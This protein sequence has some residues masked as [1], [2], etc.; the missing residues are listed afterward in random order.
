[1]DF[2]LN[3]VT[4]AIVLNAVRTKVKR[5]NNAGAGAN[6]K[7]AGIYFGQ[8]HSEQ[9]DR[10]KHWWSH[11]HVLFALNY[12]FAQRLAYNSFPRKCFPLNSLDPFEERAKKVKHNFGQIY[13]LQNLYV[14]IT[15]FLVSF[16][17]FLFIYLLFPFLPLSLSLALPCLHFLAKY[18]LKSN[19]IAWRW[20]KVKENSALIPLFDD[21]VQSSRKIGL[22]EAK[23]QHQ[24]GKH[25]EQT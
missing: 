12:V 7:P 6:V 24:N 22:K 9:S 21:F 5:A 23:N 11:S 13:S 20:R 16:H 14:Y 10:N 25:Q 1:M 3:F 4:D 18:Q 19:K 15:L 8:L 17:R 2:L